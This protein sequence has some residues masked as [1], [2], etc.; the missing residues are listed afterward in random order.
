MWLQYK[1]ENEYE[2]ILVNCF[3]RKLSINVKN[4]GVDFGYLNVK[5]MLCFFNKD[6]LLENTI[7][8]NKAKLFIKF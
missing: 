5:A 7:F 8:Y 4:D 2:S 6:T 3:K 1:K